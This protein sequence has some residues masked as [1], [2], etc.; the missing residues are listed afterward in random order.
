MHYIVLNYIQTLGCILPR[1]DHL[2]YVVRFHLTPNYECIE[3]RQRPAFQKSDGKVK[4]IK[5]PIFFFL[6]Y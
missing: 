6:N 2:V 5:L 4:D 1:Y 3:M